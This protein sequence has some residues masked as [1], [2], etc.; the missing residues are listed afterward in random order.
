MT[1]VLVKSYIKTM[2]RKNTI[3]TIVPSQKTM[4]VLITF[5]PIIDDSEIIIRIPSIYYLVQ[6]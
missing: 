3:S 4:L 1:I 2:I 5:M 6:F